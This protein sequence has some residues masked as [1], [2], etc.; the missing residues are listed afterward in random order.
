MIRPEN[1]NID[2]TVNEPIQYKGQ[3]YSNVVTRLNWTPEKRKDYQ[4]LTRYGTHD[5]YCHPI[6][7]ESS[8]PV[9]YP[10]AAEEK[11]YILPATKCASGSAPPGQLH[12]S[13][14]I[15]MTII[16]FLG[17]ILYANV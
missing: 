17:L 14:G 3:M 4:D 6:G 2:P 7:G 10:K 9:S 13:S 15:T 8:V 1:E 5:S 11:P 16:S 12:G